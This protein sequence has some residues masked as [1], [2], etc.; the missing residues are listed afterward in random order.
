MNEPTSEQLNSM[1]GLDSKPQPTSPNREKADLLAQAMVDTY[2][3]GIE[4]V[5]QMSAYIATGA[6]STVSRLTVKE[7]N[8]LRDDLIEELEQ[9]RAILVSALSDT[10]MRDF[11]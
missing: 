9:A 6:T 11:D 10:Y 2:A 7:A 5:V 3:R 1:F 8:K 4:S